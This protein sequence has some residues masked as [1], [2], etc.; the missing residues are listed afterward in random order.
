MK[1]TSPILVVM[2]LALLSVLLI[3]PVYACEFRLHKFEDLNGNGVQDAGEENIPGWEMRI[4]RAS[5]D[6]W[7]LDETGFTGPDGM[8][9]FIN[10]PGGL[11][12]RIWETAVEC[13]EP[14]TNPTVCIILEGG[15]QTCSMEVLNIWDG[16]YYVQVFAPSGSDVSVEFANSYECNGDGDGCTPGYW[17]NIRQH[18]D[19]WMVAGYDPYEDYFDV[20][21]GCGPHITLNDTVRA[22]GGSDGKLYRFATAALLDSAHPSVDNGLTEGEVIDMTCAALGAGNWDVFDG[23]F[24]DETCPLD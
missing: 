15:T 9:L 1:R 8:V 19:E 21:F 23:Y 10:K 22:R 12:W 2:L 6:T 5:G 4:Y 20:V 7:I 11:T 18:G 13:W 17:R 16:G 3:N 24:D 14:T